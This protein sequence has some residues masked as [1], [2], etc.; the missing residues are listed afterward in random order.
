MLIGLGC[1]AW[2]EV[3]DRLAVSGWGVVVAHQ[4]LFLFRHRSGKKGRV[5]DDG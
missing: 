4:G 1:V 3:V 2:I 5:V